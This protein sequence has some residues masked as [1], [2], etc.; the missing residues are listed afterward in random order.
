MSW[1]CPIENCDYTTASAR[2]RG[3]HLLRVHGML[4]QSHGRP[5]IMIPPDELQERL[6]ALRRR[7]RGSRQRKRDAIRE[8]SAVSAVGGEVAAQSHSGPVAGASSA[9]ACMSTTDVPPVLSE[10]EDWGDAV[11]EVLDLTEDDWNAVMT[12]LVDPA[13]TQLVPWVP[14]ERPPSMEIPG[15][16]SLSALCQL[17]WGN[18]ATLDEALEQVDVGDDERPLL[19]LLLEVA[20]ASGRYV[21]GSML[22]VLTTDIA[23]D[24][25][26]VTALARLIS[27]L[28][29]VCNRRQ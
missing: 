18:G 29:S 13:A 12:G 14:P 28:C 3:P 22:S 16:L 24:P 8:S 20:L 1:S 17:V 11:V 7:Q 19:R 27:T 9:A 6:Q 4:F 2:M 26:G 25:S 5:P 23:V 10:E 21:T 15:G